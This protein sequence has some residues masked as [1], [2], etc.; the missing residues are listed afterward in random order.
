[1]DRK[2]FDYLKSKGDKCS[3]DFGPHPRSYNPLLEF[4]KEVSCK[5]KVHTHILADMLN[6]KGLHASGP[7]FLNAFLARLKGSHIKP[8]DIDKDSISIW[9]E[10]IIRLEDSEREKY[11]PAGKTFRR[12]DI[13]I[14]GE[15]HNGDQFAI[16]IEN[17]LNGAKYQEYQLEAY[18]NLVSHLIGDS[19][20]VQIVCLLKGNYMDA[21]ESAIRLFP[22]DISDIIEQSCFSSPELNAV[23]KPYILYLK[24]LEMDKNSLNNARLLAGDKFSGEDIQAISAFHNA[25]QSLPEAYADIFMENFQEYIEK[26]GIKA[27]IQKNKTY[28]NYCDIWQEAIYRD[29][30]TWQWLSVGFTHKEVRFFLVSNETHPEEDAIKK[31]EQL[32]FKK[33][34]YG[35]GAIWFEYKGSN[36]T[37][38]FE[39][40]YSDNKQCP[41]KPN[42][43]N[44]NQ[45]AVA[46]LQ[47]LAGLPALLSN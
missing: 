42:I 19:Q 39:V 41:G 26:N 45:I 28:P 1:M 10:R 22:E 32:G 20:N 36:K 8:D 44:I 4:I 24:D 33:H 40:P 14:E 6:P 15:Y 38:P 25:Y 29:K 5:E 34:S 27:K 2:A 47:L 9:E 31:A 18:S 11:D 16:V 35:G 46:Y 3:F 23:L 17:K 43:Q 21:D 7:S 12:I 13:M 37:Y 30:R